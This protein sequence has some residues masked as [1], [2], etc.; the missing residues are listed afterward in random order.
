VHEKQYIGMVVVVLDH[1][2]IEKIIANYFPQVGALGDIVVARDNKAG[3]QVP[4]TGV[5]LFGTKQD[6]HAA[7]KQVFSLKVA[8][9]LSYATTDNF[10]SSVDRF[11]KKLIASTRDFLILERWGIT[12]FEDV[13]ARTHYFNLVGKLALL[14][15]LLGLLLG[16]G[17]IVLHARDIAFFVVRKREPIVLALLGVWVLGSLYGCLYYVQSADYAQKLARDSATAKAKTD[18]QDVAALLL[19]RNYE[20]QTMVDSVVRQG[21]ALD[22]KALSHMPDGIVLGKSVK[23]G[24]T[25]DNTYVISGQT[26]VQTAETI[27][28]HLHTTPQGFWKSLGIQRVAGK[29]FYIVYGKPTTDGFMWGA[30]S[31]AALE[32]MLS[33][34]G[35]ERFKSMVIFD[36]NG[37]VIFHPNPEYM[38]HKVSMRDVMGGASDAFVAVEE[39]SRQGFSGITQSS[40]KGAGFHIIYEVVPGLQWTLAAQ[41]QEREFF[42]FTH[43]LYISL[44]LAIILFAFWLM[45]CA[46]LFLRL[47]ECTFDAL[48]RMSPAYVGLC[49]ALMI[50]IIVLNNRYHNVQFTHHPRIGSRADID[51]MRDIVT[52]QLNK[53]PVPITMGIQLTYLDIITPNKIDFNARV[54]QSVDRSKYP[55][56]KL[57][58]FIENASGEITAHLISTQQKG[59]VEIAQWDVKGKIYQVHPWYSTVPFDV[60]TISWRF[61]PI[62]VGTPVLFEPD[63]AAYPSENPAL[64][65]GVDKIFNMKDLVIVKSFF[66]NVGTETE[67]VFAFMIVVKRNLLSVLLQYLLPLFIMLITIYMLSLLV[68]TESI[69]RVRVAMITAV[70]GLF[71]GLI[72]LHQNYRSSLVIPGIS[73]LE[74]FMVGIYMGLGFSY[75]NV[76]FW[77][78][79]QESRKYKAVLYWPVFVT[80]MLMVTIWSFV[81]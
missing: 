28:W 64:L 1:T 49:F 81:R 61:V 39:R 77:V 80:Y 57:G 30:I 43:P 10:A 18:I 29:D 58:F 47:Y 22:Q 31:F 69:N 51:R 13:T 65:P 16:I 6:P 20:I 25:W 52:A 50:S 59:S 19:R 48:S 21:G 54:W 46:G 63:L 45:G 53:K 14:L 4:D 15:L 17:R 24:D 32:Q 35:S 8:S 75:V 72:L 79:K 62:S 37:E 11:G 5:V 9:P 7:F 26:G 60:Q 42:V 23:K 56:V 70:S 36:A 27:S 40:V 44:M 3:E 78:D 67:P 73:Y 34:L 74:W 55:D 66:S 38:H 33:M 41:Y 71:F 12:V 68:I 2:V 76:L